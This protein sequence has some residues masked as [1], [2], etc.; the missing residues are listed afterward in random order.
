MLVKCKWCG[1]A[2]DAERSTRQYCCDAHRLAYCRA[3]KAGIRISKKAE[4]PTIRKKNVKEDDIAQAIAQMRGAVGVLDAATMYG[5]AS[6]RT[7]CE[8]VVRNVL[9]V[10]EGVGL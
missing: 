7:M 8:Y 6:T 4:P 3:R 1:K 9:D 10:L 2:F 5:P